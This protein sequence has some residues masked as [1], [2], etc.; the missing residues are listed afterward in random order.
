MKYSSCVATMSLVAFGVLTAQEGSDRLTKT[1]HAVGYGTGTGSTK[2]GFKGTELMAQGAGE[3]KVEAKQGY[4]RIEAKFSNL[5]PPTTFGA[6]FLTYVLWAVSTAGVTRNL[7]EIIIDKTGAGSLKVSCPIQTFSLVVTAEP[8]F[9][10]KMPSELLVLE[11]DLRKDTKGKRFIVTQYPLMKR[12]RYQQMA[13]PLAL[14]VDL[15]REPLDLYEARNAL[16][17][18]RLHAVD[19]YAADVHAKGAASLKMAEN[20]LKAKKDRKEVISL[21]RQSVQFFDDALSLA[22][23]RQEQERIDNE[24]KARELAERTAQE[25]AQQESARRARAEA[26]RARAEASQMKAQ[27]EQERARM[28][29]ERESQRR[30]HAEAERQREIAARMEAER[31]MRAADEARVSLRAKLLQQFSLVLATQDTERGLVVNMPD[32]LFE[33][34]KFSLRPDA[35]EKL[36]RIS[37]IVVNYPGLMLEAEGHTDNL[38]SA[39]Y[40][41]KLSEQRAGEVRR[42]LLSQG[43]PTHSVSWVGRGFEVPVASNNTA[44]GRRQNRRVELIVSGEVIGTR[45]GSTNR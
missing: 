4:T 16:A 24:R 32:V 5:A 33:S 22:L 28:E 31:R 3:A 30:R 14:T 40:N 37:G 26:D 42:Y 11:Q 15:K 8:Y 20:A 10:V 43:V 45:V 1:T 6:E 38:G 7:G 41:L 34:G 27:L 25:R 44:A 2:V 21:A 23:Q 12:A 35:R 13:N 39:K 9:A 18:A 36:A 17:I 19:R 29:V